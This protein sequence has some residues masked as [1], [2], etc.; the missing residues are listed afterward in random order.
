MSDPSIET[1][2]TTLKAIKDLVSRFLKSQRDSE[3]QEFS[4]EIMGQVLEFQSGLFDVRD[5]LLAQQD[6]IRDLKE[7]LSLKDEVFW[8]P[9]FWWKRVGDQKE[10]P[11]CQKC[12]DVESKLVHLVEDTVRGLWHCNKCKSSYYGPTFRRPPDDYL[13]ASDP[14]QY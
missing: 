6:E 12:H 8:E 2:L 3:T 1:L 13:V 5:Q 7:K 14:L 9:P 11:Y 4:G 10:G